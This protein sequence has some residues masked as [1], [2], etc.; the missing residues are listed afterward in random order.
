MFTFNLHVAGTSVA[1]RFA[2]TL[3]VV[4]SWGASWLVVTEAQY[5]NHVMC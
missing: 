1:A 2:E 4:K 5:Y 3:D